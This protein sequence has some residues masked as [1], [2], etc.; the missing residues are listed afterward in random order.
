MREMQLS[1]VLFGFCI[2]MKESLELWA[3][4]NSFFPVLLWL[5]YFMLAT[6]I[7]LEQGSNPCN[8]SC[9]PFHDFLRQTLYSYCHEKFALIGKSQFVL[10]ASC[11]IV[12]SFCGF[13]QTLWYH[14]NTRITGIYKNAFHLR[15]P[16]LLR[17][18]RERMGTGRFHQFLPQ[19][20]LRKESSIANF[21]FI[22][23]FF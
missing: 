17:E 15:A 8:S 10:Y 19:K 12:F 6:G 11:A 7:K 20:L 1:E 4:I 13:A 2:M 18:V 21:L 23:I 9:L 22:L 3:E 14:H 5:G 16:H